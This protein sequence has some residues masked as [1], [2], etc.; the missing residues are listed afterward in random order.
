MSMGIANAFAIS[1]TVNRDSTY[2]GDTS[3]AGREYSYKQI[4]HATMNGTHT[5][6][7]GGYG[8][9]GAPGDIT[10]AGTATGF[11]YYLDAEDDAAQIAQLGRWVPADPDATPAVTAHWERATGNDW[12]DLTPSADGSQYFVTWVG[13]NETSATAQEAA[14]WLNEH[15]TAIASGDLDFASGVWTKDGLEAG[16]YLIVSDTGNNLV[17]ATTDITVNEKNSYPPLE[18]TEADEDNTTL[19]DTERS[20]AIGDVLNYEVKVTIPQT[21]KVGDRILV[22][23]K[24]S[25]GLTYNND[26][27]VKT[28]TNTGNADVADP[29]TG[30]AVDGAAWTKVITIT[31][32]AQKGTDVVFTFTM[33]VNDDA[34]VDT[35]KK[36]ESGLKYGDEDGFTYESIPDHVEYN[37]KYAGI[38]KID[39]TTKEDLE[40][41]KFALKENGV[42]FNV[43]KVSGEDYYIPGGTSNEV[44]TDANGLIHIRGLDGDKSYTLTETETLPGYNMLTEDVPLTLHDDTAIST[45]TDVDG[46]VTTTVTEA[47]DGA[48]DK[49]WENEVEN[50]TGTVLPSTGGIGTTIF[51][52]VGSIMVVAAGVLLITKKRMSREG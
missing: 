9:D 13:N 3:A 48:T 19:N 15:Y 50:N 2:A 33:T 38:H 29:A 12:F 42:A 18:K 26:V 34:L 40:G 1:I 24:A 28:G 27:A 32:L 25:K 21:V 11:S 8:T 22:W 14:K 52:V 23:D 45:T 30:D 49:E 6:S 44:V 39:G 4:F 17:A 10:D 47:Y 51:Y 41:V 20:V 37:T 5:T 43:T 46:T 16:Y 31:N 7:G 36:N 35:D